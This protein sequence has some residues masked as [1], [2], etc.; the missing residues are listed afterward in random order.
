MGELEAS[1]GVKLKVNMDLL[2]LDCLQ[3]IVPEIV[4]DMTVK[5][6]VGYHH[7][8]TFLAELPQPRRF[9]F[10]SWTAY[11]SVSVA[12]LSLTT[13]AN[14]H[15]VSNQRWSMK[16]FSVLHVEELKVAAERLKVEFGVSVEVTLEQLEPDP[17]RRWWESD[18]DDF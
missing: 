13:D 12:T 1:P 14:P 17:P 15:N 9:L 5:H 11:P 6:D 10:W 16:V 2:V 8:F 4:P 3:Q 7:R 18:G